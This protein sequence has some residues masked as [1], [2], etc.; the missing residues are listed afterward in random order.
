MKTVI[1]SAALCLSISACASS[2]DQT[3][4]D[5]PTLVESLGDRNEHI[6]CGAIPDE[7]Q[8]YA[9]S[10]CGAPLP[11]VQ[12]NKKDQWKDKKKELDQS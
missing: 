5:T 4:P 1:I 9:N 6:N 7:S 10:N 8:R 3:T 11:N 2:S 12:K